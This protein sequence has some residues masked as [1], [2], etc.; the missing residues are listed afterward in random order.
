MDRRTFEA[1]PE[2]CAGCTMACPR[3][4]RIVLRGGPWDGQETAVTRAAQY[5]EVPHDAEGRLR[6]PGV[7]YV[8][9]AEAERGMPVWRPGT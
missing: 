6:A 7:R 3:L 8:P 4:L 1:C 9:T 2:G 5:C